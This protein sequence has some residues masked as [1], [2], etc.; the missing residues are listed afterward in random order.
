MELAVGAAAIALGVAGLYY[1]SRLLSG[2]QSGP[3]AAAPV[4]PPPMIGVLEKERLLLAA[5]PFATDLSLLPKTTEGVPSIVEAILP[6][7]MSRGR[8][9][10]VCRTSGAHSEV[11]Q[12]A[13][14]I[15]NGVNVKMEDQTV[16]NLVGLLKKFLMLLPD[17]LLT[18]SLYDDW[19]ELG[20]S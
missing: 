5:G 3:V 16:E 12:I 2:A 6:I 7:I 13:L 20:L 1:A 11:L 9:E 19:V 15:T 14:D 18:F 8:Y 10:G 4:A 17:P